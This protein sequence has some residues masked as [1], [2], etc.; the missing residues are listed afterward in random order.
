MRDLHCHGHHYLLPW[1]SLLDA[2]QH[3]A[4][5]SQ[6]SLLHAV[7]NIDYPITKLLGPGLGLYTTCKSIKQS[8]LGFV[9]ETRMVVTKLVRLL[10]LYAFEI[11][12]VRACIPLLVVAANE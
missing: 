6:T 7:V 5:G 2:S 3:G 11:V 8:G 1:P 10:R 9:P 4:L 12:V